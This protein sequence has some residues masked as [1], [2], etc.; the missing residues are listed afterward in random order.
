MKINEVTE[1]AI[2]PSLVAVAEFL[3]SRQEDVGAGLSMNLDAFVN[4]LQS[5]GINISKDKLRDIQPNLKNVIANITDN[6]VI[7]K[8]AGEVDA[9]AMTVDKAKNTVEKM[10]KRALPNDLK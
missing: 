2:D 9:P 4:M 6:E 8:G 3:K 7:F 1:A 5:N 10:A